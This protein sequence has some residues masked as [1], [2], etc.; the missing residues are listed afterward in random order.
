MIITI[1]YEPQQPIY[2]S[3]FQLVAQC[4]AFLDQDIKVWGVH[5]SLAQ[6][7][8]GFLSLLVGLAR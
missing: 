7:Q 3:S 2:T 1:F 4:G 8:L 5:P 6:T